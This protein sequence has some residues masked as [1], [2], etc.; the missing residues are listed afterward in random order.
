[1]LY[2]PAG[3]KSDYE[4]TDVWQDFNIIE[5]PNFSEE[6]ITITPSDSTAK[7]EWQHYENAEGYRLIIYSDE[8]H[9]NIVCILELDAEGKIPAPKEAKSV[10]K[11]ASEVR[12]YTVDN[13]LSGKDYYYT[14][15]ILGVGNVVLASQSGTFTTNT[16][17]GIVE[18]GRAPSLPK[19]AGY[20]NIFGAKLPKE[21]ASGIYIVKYDNGKTEKVIK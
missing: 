12:S 7:I 1:M 18:T 19:L 3:S 20:Y 15:E 11:V 8:T 14:L 10:M 2:V 5:L 9:T 13:L 16:I 21:P 17:T 6:D 4:D